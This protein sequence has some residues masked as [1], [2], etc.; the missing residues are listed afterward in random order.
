MLTPI[1]SVINSQGVWKEANKPN[2][3]FAFSFDA[4]GNIIISE[5]DDKGN[6]TPRLS[7]TPTSPLNVPA[8]EVSV[9][10]DMVGDI[11]VVGHYAFCVVLYEVKNGQADL[12]PTLQLIFTKII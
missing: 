7:L 4:T 11:A 1:T 5:L 8:A 9:G 2:T 12:A 6:K 10:T 3:L